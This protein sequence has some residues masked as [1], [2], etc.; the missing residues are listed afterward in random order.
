MKMKYSK[1]VVAIA[2][3]AS[4][5]AM[6]AGFGLYE[7][8][9]RGLGMGN[10]LVGSTGDASANYHNPANLT[11]VTSPSVMV[12]M[13]LINPFCDVKVDGQTQ[14]KMN[15]GWFTPPHAYVAVPV[16]KDLVLGFGSYCE[17]GLGSQYD[18]DWML[19]GDTTETTIQQFTFNPNIAYRITEDWSVA[20]GARMSYITF[21]NYKSPYFGH[22]LAGDLFGRSHLEGDDFNCGYMLATQYKV[23]D[24]LSLGLVYR[25]RIK[26]RIEG[27]FDMTYPALL[28]Y[29]PN[30]GDAEAKV[31]LPASITFGANYEF[32]EKFR[33][34]ASLTW[35]EWSTINHID[36]NLPPPAAYTQN[37]NWHDAWRLGFGFEY[38]LTDALTGRI[39]YTF[40]W[41]PS[42]EAHGTTMLPP[43]DR[44]II[45]FGA[46]Y[47]FLK[48]WR[49]DL[50]YSFILMESETRMVDV[51]NNI[52]PGSTASHRFQCDNSYSHLISASVS[53]TF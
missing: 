11:E 32:T 46:S 37:L 28:G 8:S 31:V 49:V 2:A 13:T 42:A 7:A 29:P 9:A 1:L 16:L 43:G 21:E 22:P 47:S 19:K 6:G 50:G 51:K 36:F 35:T 45:G 3:M 40:D 48:N 52:P 23:T 39:G 53:Y 24:D 17:F 4:A 38:D 10:G 12:G 27:D 14:P 5:S 26:H 15:A 33:S 44:H 34:G 25:S 18:N 20:F 41:D 30:I